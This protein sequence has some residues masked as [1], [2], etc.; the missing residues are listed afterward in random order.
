MGCDGRC[1]VRRVHSRRAKRSQRTAKSCGSG[2]AT[3]ASIFAGAI[4]RDNGDN[5]RRSPGRARISRKAIARGKPGCLGCTCQIRVH[6]STTSAHGNAGAV[7]ARLSLRPFFPKGPMRLQ[8]PGE[9]CRGDASVCLPVIAR[10]EATKQ[11]SATRA[12]LDCFASLAM[13]SYQRGASVMKQPCVYIVANRRNGTLY[14][15]SRRT[16]PS[17][18]MNIVRD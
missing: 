5:K 11:S 3:V 15:A 17:G 7:G 16:C 13:T 1:G 14:A 6:S 4:S 2:A 9:M 8:N 18:P 10:S 12:T